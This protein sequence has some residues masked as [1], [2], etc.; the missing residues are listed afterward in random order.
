MLELQRQPDGTGGGA[1]AKGNGRAGRVAGIVG[2]CTAVHTQ[3][4]SGRIAG[5]RKDAGLGKAGNGI[6][7]LPLLL[8]Y[9]KEKRYCPTKKQ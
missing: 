5:K 6:A 9:C 8:R 3:K 7:L 2:V 1:D 4:D